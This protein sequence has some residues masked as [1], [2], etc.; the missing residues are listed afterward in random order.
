MQ[1]RLLILPIALGI[2]LWLYYP[3]ANYGV[4]TDYLGWLNK[5][6]A[7]NWGDVIHCFNYPGLHQVFHFI[8]YLIYK[9]TLAD[10]FGLY[11]IFSLTHGLVSYLLYRAL[12]RF[13]EWLKWSS[14]GT[15]S[16][17]VGVLFLLS[18]YQV[19][20]VTWKACYHYLMVTGFMSGGLVYLIKYFEDKKWSS[21]AIHF[22]FFLLSLGTIELGLILPGI[23][24]LVYLAYFW[25]HGDRNVLI[26][27]IKLNVGHLILLMGYFLL[28]KLVIGTYIGHYGAEKHL[29]FDPFVL[30]STASKYVLKYLAFTH[31]LE[32]QPRYDLYA[33]LSHPIKGLSVIIPY[34]SL[35]VFCV[36]KGKKDTSW[37]MIGFGLVGFLIA[38]LPVLNLYFMNLHPYENDRYGYLASAFIYLAIIGLIYKFIGRYKYWVSMLF[39]GISLYFT[40][41]TID[42]VHN[43]GT[44]I[45]ALVEDFK[46][47]EAERVVIGGVPENYNGVYML[48]DLDDK[49]LGLIESVDWIGGR[50]VAGDV[51]VLSKY[52]VI[53]TS[54]H[55]DMKMLDSTTVQVWN[56]KGGSWFWRK[57]VGMQEYSKEGV[58]VTMKDAHF[59][60]RILSVPE[61]TIF[62]YPTGQTWKKIEQK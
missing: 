3:T 59:D 32:F 58:E 2:S 49:G 8:N 56:I 14:A 5:Y 36:I 54:V 51:N 53:D 50:K 57:G 23:Y 24:G 22:L 16:F 37:L 31:Y 35:I 6:R 4:V 25:R 52:N 17:F 19:E 7:G 42:D 43:A 48:R 47:E 15:V 33:W 29:A 39:I 40:V 12:R 62:I 38:L 60:A 10:Q 28:T 21:L 41:K 46:Y 18:P 55:L 27:G 1:L 20:P 30:T 61:G 26:R 13:G 11:M 44:I 9:I 45:N 34:L